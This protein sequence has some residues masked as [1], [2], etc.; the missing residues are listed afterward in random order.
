MKRVTANDPAAL[1]FIGTERYH[2]GDHD[3]AIE[4]WTKAAELGDLEAHY[5]LSVV[6]RDGEGVEKDKEKEIYHLEKA[7]IGGHPDARHNLGCYEKRIGN[8]ERA[9]KHSIIAAKL[10]DEISMKALWGVYKDGYITKEELEETLR[11]HKAAIDEMKSP[12][13]EAAYKMRK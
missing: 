5:Q 3:S 11:T 10:G 7:A 13:R 4:Y 12:E 8:I 2:E 9:V 1:R 6:Y